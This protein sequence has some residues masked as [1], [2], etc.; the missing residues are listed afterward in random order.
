MARVKE[1]QNRSAD[2]QGLRYLLSVPSQK[3]LPTPVLA[4]AYL[5]CGSL[6]PTPC[7]RIRVS[8]DRTWSSVFQQLLHKIFN[9]KHAVITGMEMQLGKVG[10]TVFKFPTYC[11]HKK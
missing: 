9:E 7:K 11:L 3:S 5:Q 2:T 6:A 1:L 4:D 8:V 10:D